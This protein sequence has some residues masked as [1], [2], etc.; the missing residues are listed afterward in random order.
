MIRKRLRD[1]ITIQEFT[2]SRSAS[3]QHI[4][5]WQDVDTVRA[6]VESVSGRE[7][8]SADQR[9]TSVTTKIYIRY[10]SGITPSMRVVHGSVT[11]DIIAVLGGDTPRDM[12]TLMC[13]RSK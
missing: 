3:G 7:W 11:Y 9:Q 12:V 13:E 5:T 4:E 8:F 6:R 2:S 10:R 1:V